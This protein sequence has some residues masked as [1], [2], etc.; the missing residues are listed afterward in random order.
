M[1]RTFSLW[2]LLVCISFA[3]FV[4]SLAVY[5][6][7]EQQ[8]RDWYDGPKIGLALWR[9]TNEQFREMN[10]VT[11][12]FLAGCERYQHS[13]YRDFTYNDCKAQF[14]QLSATGVHHR[15]L[16]RMQT[17]KLT[18]KIVAMMRLN[19][20]RGH[21]LVYEFSRDN[22]ADWL[23]ETWGT[24]DILFGMD[25]LETFRMAILDQE[26]F[27]RDELA[28]GRDGKRH[29]ERQIG[30]FFEMYDPQLAEIRAVLL[31]E[32][33]CRL[34]SDK[35]LGEQRRQAGLRIIDSHRIQKSHV[36]EYPVNNLDSED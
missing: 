33:W 21:Q 12:D 8:F 9:G 15:E 31:V 24:Y 29:I 27:L 10:K 25:S 5:Y 28:A 13:Y 35:T 14:E 34:S 6:H 32:T 16:T 26:S 3:I 19:G 23:C 17:A 20:R 30:A 18:R 4:F 22:P 36:Q 1:W 2:K 7:R 11:D